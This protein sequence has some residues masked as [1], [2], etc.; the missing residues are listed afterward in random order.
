MKLRLFAAINLPEDLKR[1]IA[2]KVDYLK[3]LLNFS[4]RF[5]DSENWHLTLTFLGYQ[6]EQYLS[7]ILAALK[8]T[9]LKFSPPKIEVIDL[10]YGP[11]STDFKTVQP[12]MIWLNC[13]EETSRRLAQIK[14][15]LE[16]QLVGLGVHFKRESRLFKAHLTLGRFESVPR[17]RLPLISEKFIY[18]FYP[19][20]LDLMESHLKRAGAQY[21]L[22]SGFAFHNEL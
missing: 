9:A 22:L 2:A 12:R 8:D 19:S 10:D 18:E 7:S 11:S 1:K 14:S 20:K 13:S 16:N 17:S 3:G 21:E 4:I 15:E 5:P 6:D